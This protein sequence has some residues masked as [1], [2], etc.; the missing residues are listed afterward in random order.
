VCYPEIRPGRRPQA[1]SPDV[2]FDAIRGADLVALRV[3]AFGLELIPG[4]EPVLRVGD[5]D[6][7]LVVHYTFQQ[8]AER[9][10]YEV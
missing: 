7:H 1:P 5:T 10:I 8:I 4:G 2:V 9:A 6:G 3:E